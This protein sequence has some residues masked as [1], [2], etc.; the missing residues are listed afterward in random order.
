M[1]N[2]RQSPD[3]DLGARRSDDG[4]VGAAGPGE[5]TDGAPVTLVATLDGDARIRQGAQDLA[6]VVALLGSSGHRELR[7]SVGFVVVGGAEIDL[8]RRSGA[9]G[10]SWC[11][12]SAGA[13]WLASVRRLRRRE[14][15]AGDV[16]QLPDASD[17]G[18]VSFWRGWVPKQLLDQL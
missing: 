1:E 5:V 3:E 8:D 10:V 9:V 4:A 18:V 17:L 16:S 2:A 7:G 12:R 6:V 14:L 13:L 11:L 15:V